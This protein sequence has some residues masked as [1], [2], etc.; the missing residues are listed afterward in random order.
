MTKPMYKH[1]E[2]EPLIEIRHKWLGTAE[3]LSWLLVGLLWALTTLGQVRG[4]PLIPKERLTSNPILLAIS[5]TAIAFF[6]VSIS[7]SAGGSTS[8]VRA[9]AKMAGLIAAALALLVTIKSGGIYDYVAYKNHWQSIIDG[10]HPWEG[11]F[12]GGSNTY[13]PTYNFLAILYAH[14]DLLPKV[15]TSFLCII[16]LLLFI[17]AENRTKSS[18]DI[19]FSTV[20]GPVVI[21]CVFVYGFIDGLVA[22]ITWIGVYSSK[23][24]R[25]GLAGLAIAV[26]TGIKFYPL[27]ILPSLIAGAF[28]SRNTLRSVTVLGVGFIA[29]IIVIGGISF[30]IWNDFG[31]SPFLLASSRFPSFLTA[32]RWAPGYAVGLSPYLATMYYALITCLSFRM[33]MKGNLGVAQSCIAGF[34]S[35]FGL[36]YLGHQQFYIIIVM[37][38]AL[39]ISESEDRCRQ[40]QDERLPRYL[41]QYCILLLVGWITF[42]Q[43]SFDI[44]GEFRTTGTEGVFLDLLSAINTSILILAPIGIV[45]G[46]K[47]SLTLIRRLGVFCRG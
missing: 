40:I 19:A 43:V 5:L 2:R 18:L 26:A 34:C 29:G 16:V 39:A 33:V 3:R 1:G 36:Y 42:V 32:W 41:S 4:I 13:G 20:V 45:L 30:L 17:R 10:G 35:I 25:P 14:W 46:K 15:A 24:K 38:S 12:K 47:S 7:R 11:T 27:I 37:L 21:S 6:S 9:S 22:A 8:R 44:L 31:L 28:R 23:I